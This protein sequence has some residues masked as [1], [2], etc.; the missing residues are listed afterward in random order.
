MSHTMKSMWGLFIGTAAL[1]TLVAAPLRAETN[2]GK[3][4]YLKY[5]SACHGESAK[6]DGVVSGFMQPKPTDLTQ[7]AKQNHGEFP[8]LL[9]VQGI[10]GTKTVRAHGDSAMPV[11]GETF[12]REGVG[13][14]VMSPEANV[15]GKVMLIADYLRGIQEK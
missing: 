6:G 7:L 8:M 14:S 3:A 13:A 15:R 9:V 10:D 11:W 1:T 2:Q 5:C 12:R 4:A